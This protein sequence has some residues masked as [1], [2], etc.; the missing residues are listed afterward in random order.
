MKFDPCPFCGKTKFDVNNPLLHPDMKLILDTLNSLIKEFGIADSLHFVGHTI[1]QKEYNQILELGFDAVNVVR[2]GEHRFNRNVIKKIPFK[3]IQFKLFNKPLKLN[4][5]FI[6]KYFIDVKIDI[7]ENVYP[8]LIPNWDHTPRSGNKGVVFHGAT[9]ERFKKN[10]T[11]ILNL[12]KRIENQ[13]GFL[14]SWNEWGEV[15]YMEPCLKYGKGY[16]IA[17]KNAINEIYR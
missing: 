3:L 14:K 15:N 16:I 17:L 9:P 2:I 4:Y 11:Q 8:T 12:V 10:V 5:S 1:N 6:S 13:L 7:K